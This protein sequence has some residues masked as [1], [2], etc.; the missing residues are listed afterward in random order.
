MLR[1]GDAFIKDKEPKRLLSIRGRYAM[2]D[3]L[4]SS[5]EGSSHG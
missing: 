4:D 1:L 2:Y 5:G 3:A